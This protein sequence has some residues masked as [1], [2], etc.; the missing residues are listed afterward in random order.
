MFYGYSV[1]NR[2]YQGKW[3][4]AQREADTLSLDTELD[5]EVAAA[6][7]EA[8][9]THAE[10]VARKAMPAPPAV[11]V[12]PLTQ[13]SVMDVEEVE[14]A[15][16]LVAGARAASSDVPSVASSGVKVSRYSFL[17]F[18][19]DNRLVGAVYRSRG[20]RRG[21]HIEEEDRASFYL[22]ATARGHR[23]PRRHLPA[24]EHGRYL[25]EGDG[26]S[27]RA[28]QSLEVAMQS[29]AGKARAKEEGC[30]GGRGEGPKM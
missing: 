12:G 24:C 23:K 19:A 27:V 29:G 21:R 13:E 4:T 2:L 8:E 1:A 9:R 5:D 25:R 15:V 16:G 30:G 10:W 18:L 26:S 22:G 28:L 6:I 7:V 11:D 3:E 17:L 20:S 14:R